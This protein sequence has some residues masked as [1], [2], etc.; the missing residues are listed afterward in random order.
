MIYDEADLYSL[1]HWE[2]DGGSGIYAVN[3]LN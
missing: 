2:I 3:I 1:A